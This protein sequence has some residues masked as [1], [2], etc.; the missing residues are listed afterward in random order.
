MNAPLVVEGVSDTARWTAYCRALESERPDALFCDPF[1]RSLAGERGRTIAEEMPAAAGMRPGASGFAPVLAV[2]TAVFDDLILES[3]EATRAG[4]VLN[5]GAGLD[6]RPY[7]LPLPPSL[8]WIE[9]DEPA[10]LEAKAVVL[11]GERPA[12]KVE[13]VAVDLADDVARRSAFDRVAAAHER[14]VVV[15]EG[16]LI[17]LDEAVVATLARDLRARAPMQRWVLETMSPEMV[18]RNMRARGKALANAQWK[19]A[20]P[21]GFDFFRR[22]GWSLAARRPFFA[23]ACRLGRVKELRFN[24]F[25]RSLAACS[26]RFRTWLDDSVVYGIVEPCLETASTHSRKH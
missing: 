21:D 25:V 3:I 6:A 8:V 5:L 4:A 24:R 11:A 14:V 26:T 13:R 17:Y 19:F 12:C 18:R 2:R 1:A 10:I 15:S 16:L 20:P 23:E 9:A 7:R 22:H